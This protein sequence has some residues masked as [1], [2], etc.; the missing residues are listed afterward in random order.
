MTALK[1]LCLFKVKY[2]NNL[3][4]PWKSLYT[5]EL[6]QFATW[7]FWHPVTYNKHFWSQNISLSCLLKRTCIFWNVHFRHLTLFNSYSVINSTYLILSYHTFNFYLI[8]ELP[9]FHVYYYTPRKHNCELCSIKDF[10][11]HWVLL[12]LC[13][14]GL[15]NFETIQYALCHHKFY[16]MINQKN[17]KLCTLQDPNM[18]ICTLVVYPGPLSFPRIMS[19]KVVFHICF[20]S[21]KMMRTRGVL[22]P[23]SRQLVIPF[24]YQCGTPASSSTSS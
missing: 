12:L 2:R 10:I 5:M 14:Y 7:V 13:L 23:H 3:V 20:G 11:V 19:L 22:V 4:S 1:P 9:C 8:N 16:Y 15:R 21:I 18:K 17:M 6:V 24:M